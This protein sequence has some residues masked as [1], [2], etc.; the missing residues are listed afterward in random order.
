MISITYFSTCQWGVI[1]VFSPALLSFLP[2]AE[3]LKESMGSLPTTNCV[4]LSGGLDS[5]ALV[6][7]SLAE[8]RSVFPLYVRCGFL[9]ESAELYWLRRLLHFYGNRRVLP[10]KIVEMPMRP[11]YGSHWSLS[12]KRVPSSK[13]P[14]KA[15]FLPGRNA[16]LLTAAAIVAVRHKASR[17][18]LG[19]LRGNPFGDATPQFFRK[20]TS[21]LSLALKTRL[22]IAAPLRAMS[23]QELIA[24]SPGVPFALTFSCIQ[25]K[26]RY[27]HCG[28]CNKCAER[29][30][31]FRQAGVYDPTR[32]I[33]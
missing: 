9:W 8:G 12:G 17:I 30:R 1:N 29:K 21:A 3:I 23:K 15:V 28:R 33:H 32:Y 19:V 7:R 2:A 20:L 13:S 4:L 16:V 25:P 31:A 27:H 11:L 14:D 6:S 24:A 10:L 5:A 18:S 22:T 26:L